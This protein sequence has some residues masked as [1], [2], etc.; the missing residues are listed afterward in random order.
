MEL[1]Q[2]KM[3]HKEM[4]L[5]LLCFS[6]FSTLLLPFFSYSREASAQGSEA[7]ELEHLVVFDSS[8]RLAFIIIDGKT[9]PPTQLPVPFLWEN[10]STHTFSVVSTEII[11]ENNTHF[12]FTKWSDG[13]TDVERTIVVDGPANYTAIYTKR[14]YLSVK[15]P[16]GSPKG[17]GWYDSN[18]TA[19]FSITTPMDHENMT[20]HIFLLW[21]GDLSSTSPENLIRMDE[22]K[23]V[24]ASWK[25]Q[26]YLKV[27]SNI[28]DPKGE[29][30]YDGDSEATVS[31][32]SPTGFLIQ[33]FFEGWSGDS[34]AKSSLI[35]LRMDSPKTVTALWRTD[36]TRI[37]LLGGGIFTV[38]IILLVKRIRSRKEGS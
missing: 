1:R 3:W 24:T 25:T 7:V 21:S 16:Y 2:I 33:Q 15:S 26:Y 9:A 19:T 11:G 35:T 17:E 4:F 22:S 23:N 31:V 14:F 18:S 27:N 5:I 8:P 36:Y 28:G 20:R 29:G 12:F 32:T 6:L 38:A 10:G 34:T 30:W 37:Y 13:V